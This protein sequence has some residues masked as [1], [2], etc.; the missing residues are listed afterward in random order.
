MNKWITLHL[1]IAKYPIYKIFPLLL[2]EDSRLKDLATQAEKALEL[3]AERQ[4]LRNDIVVAQKQSETDEKL[5]NDTVK[6]MLEVVEDERERTSALFV[7]PSS[8]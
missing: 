8:A 2:S 7:D 4:K 3:D 5:I 1:D 6:A